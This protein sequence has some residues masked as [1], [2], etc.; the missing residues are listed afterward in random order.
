MCLSCAPCRGLIRKHVAMAVLCL[1]AIVAEAADGAQSRAIGY[2][3]DARHFA[4]EQYGIEDGSGSAYADIFVLDTETNT[5]VKN[6]P[7]RVLGEEGEADIAATRAKALAKAA[8]TLEL[9]NLAGAFDTLVHMPFTEIIAE[10][11]KVRFAR[12]Y[13]ST[14]DTG[15]YDA[16]GSYELQVSDTAVPTPANCPDPD[17]F[18]VVGMTLSIRNV[19]TGTVKTLA[20]DTAIPKSRSCPTA[21]DLEAVFAPTAQ[22]L[23]RDPLVALIGVYS[24]GFEGSDR[25]FIAIPFELFE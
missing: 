17:D 18:K 21:Y 13:A 5:W 20:K 12:Y 16:M 2:S 3:P 4:F 1:S 8:P 19:K 7:V 14:A 24:R 10:R 25:R 22:G 23:N 6:T 9:L 11:R 15:A